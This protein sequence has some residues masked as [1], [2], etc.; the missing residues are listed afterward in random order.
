M[1]NAGWIGCDLDGVLAHWDEA[2][3]PDIGPPIQSMIDRVRGWIE[4]G[5]D[6]RIFTA[7]VCEGSRV[8]DY[9]VF[10]MTPPQFVLD[11]QRRIESFCLTYFGVV[12]PVTC[13]KDFKMIELWDD[14][15]V[16]ME[17]NTGRTMLEVLREGL[18]GA[19]REPE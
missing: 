3:F 5:K 7:R 11:Q 6:V 9:A 12:L 10:E 17:T 15:C 18:F 1:S 14:R 16:E 19:L 13:T 4:A 8:E 2:R